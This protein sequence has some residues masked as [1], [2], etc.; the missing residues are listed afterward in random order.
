[1]SSI[2]LR[3]LLISLIGILLGVV[4]LQ[5]FKSYVPEVIFSQNL[6]EEAEVF[7]DQ[8]VSNRPV[9]VSAL[10][11]KPLFS[12]SRRAA[13]L[14]SVST[15]SQVSSKTAA[16][17]KRVRAPVLKLVGVVGAG[18]ERIAVFSGSGPGMKRKRIG[19]RLGKWLVDDVQP[20]HV[21]LKKDGQVKTYRLQGSK[22]LKGAVSV[23]SILE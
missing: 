21:V 11:A 12:Q 14:A 9:D 5:S 13:V 23:T 2:T 3:R 15:S 20:N 1:M 22:A 18:E 8:I 10:R 16:Q 4:A 6:P 7:G 19:Q 17:P